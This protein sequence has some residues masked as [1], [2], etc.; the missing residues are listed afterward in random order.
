[1]EYSAEQSEVLERHVKEHTIIS[2]PRKLKKK[3]VLLEVITNDFKD[4]RCYTEQ[5]VNTILLKWYDDY[6]ILRRY[7]V[8]FKFLKREEDGSSYYK[9]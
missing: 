2:I 5:E 6:V 4:G 8:D 1:M 7:L 9:V 3:V